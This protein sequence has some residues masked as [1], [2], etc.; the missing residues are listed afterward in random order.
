MKNKLELF[1]RQ[2]LPVLNRY[3][4]KYLTKLEGEQTLKDAMLYSVAAGGKRIRPL[5]I[6]AIC[7][8]ADQQIDTNVYA[9][10]SSLE[11]LHTYSLIHDDLPEMDNDD[12]RRGRLTNHKKFGQAIAV[13][14]G[15][16]LLTT[17]FEC[18]GKTTLSSNVKVRLMTALAEAAGP[19]GMVSGQTADIEGEH[20]RLSLAQLQQLHQHKTGALINYACYA[21]CVLGD[22]SAEKQEQVQRFGATFGLAFQIYDD[23]LDVVATEDQLGKAVHKDQSEHK[24]TYPGLVGLDGAYQHLDAA[25]QQALTSL[26]ILKEMGMSTELLNGF[27]DYFMRRKKK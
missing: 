1:Q 22:L 7:S 14:A 18:L 13:L 27:L 16:G 3:L 11:L 17:A 4:E 24:N 21:G 25:L 15:D 26:N 19:Q 12:L 2:H 23:I 5:L 20:K 6:M 9:V 8:E 10:A